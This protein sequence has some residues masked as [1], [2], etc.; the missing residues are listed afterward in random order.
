MSVRAM[1]LF[2]R[3]AGILLAALACAPGSQEPPA[4]SVKMVE[5]PAARGSGEPNLAVGDDG[6]VYLSWIE[7][8]GGDGHALRFSHWEGEGWSGPRTVASGSNWFVNWADFPSVAALEDGT[9]AAHWLAK[10]GEG[11][12]AYAVY[13]SVSG[14]GGETWSD[15]AIPHADGTKTEHGFVTLVPL[16]GGRFAL[17]W[18]DGR[19]MISGGRGA[20]TLRHALLGRDGRVGPETLVDDRVCDC[21]ATDAVRLGEEDLLVAYR[22]RSEAEIRDI[23]LVRRVEDRWSAPR[24][25]HDDGWEIP[26]CPVNGPALAGSGDEVAAAWFT[27]GTEQKPRVVVAFSKDGGRTFGGPVPVDGGRP[28]GRVDLVSLPD[29]SVLV[30]WL[31]ESE[32]AA[33]IRVRRV[34]SSGE[35][36]PH[37]VIARTDDS[38]AA[39]FPRMVPWGEKAI[40]AWTRSGNPSRILTAVV[41]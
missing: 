24:S 27:L 32:T 3:A 17:I 39:G 14:D 31:E 21:C 16:R 20:M 4:G 26:G 33:E 29:G 25:I 7:P 12:Y 15:P 2:A 36:A 6:R 23:S 10:V 35:P 11:T 28:L 19:E 41:R 8:A 38:R 9:L 1:V 34:G 5:T 13:L 37:R 30:S 22:D 40:L 18:L